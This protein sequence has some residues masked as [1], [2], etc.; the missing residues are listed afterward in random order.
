MS[1]LVKIE[2]EYKQTTVEEGTQFKGT[3][4]SSCQV[5]VR[6]I[7]EGELSAPSLVVSET[8]TVIGNIRVQSLQSAGTLAGRIEADDVQ[9][10]GHVRSDTVIRAKTM[11]VKLQGNGKPLEVTFGDCTLE[12]GDEPVGHELQHSSTKTSASKRGRRGDTSLAGSP[13]SSLPSTVAEPVET[14]KPSDENHSVS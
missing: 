13:I 1:E 14:S 7:V 8:G 10:S 3:L 4:Q 2:A 11:D 5:V 12:V 9:L 6:G